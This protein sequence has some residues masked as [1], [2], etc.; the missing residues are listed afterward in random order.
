[1][2]TPAREFPLLGLGI[3]AFGHAIA[4]SLYFLLDLA[5]DHQ[6]GVPAWAQLAIHFGGRELILAVF[7]LASMLPLAAGVQEVMNDGWP[8]IARGLGLLCAAVA[9]ALAWRWYELGR[10][11]L[12]TLAVL[13]AI[14]GLL[15]P[16]PARPAQRSAADPPPRTP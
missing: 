8:R 1:L 9:A 10:P 6:A 5:G 14:P 3:G 7:S 12:C 16:A 15:G 2:P 11:F 13:T 4:W